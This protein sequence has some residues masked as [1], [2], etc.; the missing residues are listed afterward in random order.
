MALACAV[1]LATVPLHAATGDYSERL[2]A[3]WDFQKP[4]ESEARFRAEAAR[5]PRGSRE[6][7][8]AT[9]QVGRT[10]GLQRR[11][12]AADR[13]LDAVQ[14]VLA[15]LPVRVRVRYLLER[16]RRQNSS[17]HRQ[18]AYEWFE[19]ALEASAADDVPGADFYRVDA[20]HM[21]AI[22]AP[23]AQ[24][25]A[26]NLRALAI[27]DTSPDPRTRGWRGSLL[28]NLGW[29]MH[30]RGD[31]EAA[32]AYWRDALS[33]FEAKGDVNAVRIARWTVGRGLRALGRF[34]AAE[35]MQRALAAELDAVNAPD[36]YVFE[37]LAEIAAARGDA[38]ASAAW[39]AKAL[40][41]LSQDAGLRASEPARL[42][43]LRQLARGPAR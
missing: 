8:E 30:E 17:G 28:N 2:D 7:S 19:Q 12:A 3:L 31:D 36:G 43:R 37:E 10:L 14:P 40:P 18:R 27:A 29:T 35:G 26:W 9:T 38:A 32:L 1:T 39:A 24:Q 6:A 13:A 41:L 23:L 15:H 34:D 33:A 22:A 5:H 20:L 21:L 4:A 16:G 11:F 25:R 42:A